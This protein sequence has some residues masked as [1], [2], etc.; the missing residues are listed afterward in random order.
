MGSA[1][2]GG[3]PSN[4]WSYDKSLAVHRLGAHLVSLG[5][6]VRVWAINHM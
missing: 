1:L 3:F 5:M 2:V 6:V 4:H